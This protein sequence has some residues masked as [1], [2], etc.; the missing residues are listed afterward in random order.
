[1]HT[2]EQVAAMLDDIVD[3]LPEPIVRGLNGGV[4]L[5]PD[6]V[7]SR[8]IPD[9]G[10]YTLGEYFVDRVTGRMVYL[11]YGSIMALCKDCTTE[12]LRREL[13]RVVKHELRH[14]VENL[15]GA[16]DLEVE[17]E[18][19]VRAALRKLGWRRTGSSG[20]EAK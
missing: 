2:F 3:S 17:D 15:A 6:T 1:M 4:Y 10:Y 16:R 8:K 9:P 20:P 18:E 5:L 12:E 11:Y 14:H 13:E 7:R 19:Y